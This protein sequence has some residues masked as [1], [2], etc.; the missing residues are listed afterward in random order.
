MS[1]DLNNQ[2]L[3][4]ELARQEE[5]E[6]NLD[7]RQVNLLTDPDAECECVEHHVPKPVQFERHHI[8]P[9]AWGGTNDPANVR[10]LCPTAHGNAHLLLSQLRKN[11]GRIPF[12]LARHTG[13]YIEALARWGYARW[14]EMQ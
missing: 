10:L 12:A 8:V 4:K 11:D 2:F 5:L 3:E 14:K 7:V 9:L 1:F 6:L 13:P